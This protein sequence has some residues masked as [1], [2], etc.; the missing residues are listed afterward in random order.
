MVGEWAIGDARIARGGELPVV[1]CQLPVAGGYNGA[2]RSINPA[3]EEVWEEY[4]DHDPGAVDRMLTA[5]EDAAA[6]WAV[7]PIWECSGLLL[8]VAEL[9]RERKQQ[10]AELMAREMGKPVAG[11]E[12]EVEKCA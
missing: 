9:L 1:S 5:A 3:T 10:Y 11:G 7:R 12:A 4:A 2:M 8:R 6:G